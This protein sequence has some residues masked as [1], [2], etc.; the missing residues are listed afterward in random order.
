M[1]TVKFVQPCVLDEGDVPEVGATREV[2]AERAEALVAEGVAELVR[3]GSG[4]DA[5][6][7]T[8]RRGRPP[9]NPVAE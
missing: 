7:A 2:D 9:K 4:D 8:P 1:P 3:R 5:E 6:K